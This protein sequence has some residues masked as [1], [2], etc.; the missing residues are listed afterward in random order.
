MMTPSETLQ[1]RFM[2]PG[3]PARLGMIVI[4][5][6]IMVMLGWGALAPLPARL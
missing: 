1:N 4:V 6:F 5:A 2:Q 3:V